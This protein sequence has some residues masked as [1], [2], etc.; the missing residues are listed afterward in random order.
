MRW[1]FTLGVVGPG[2]KAPVDE[3]PP[4]QKPEQQPLE[5]PEQAAPDAPAADEAERR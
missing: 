4:P 3:P 5:L 1:I 2:W